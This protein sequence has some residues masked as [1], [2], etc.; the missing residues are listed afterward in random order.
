MEAILI[1][2]RPRS[3]KSTLAIILKRYIGDKA[4]ILDGDDLRNSLDYTD[5][6]EEGR[7]RWI[8]RVAS[9]AL[10]FVRQGFCPII[11]L[12]SPYAGVRKEI[13]EIFK[14]NDIDFTLF[15]VDGA[16]DRMWSGSVYEEPQ[17]DEQPITI[18]FPKGFDYAKVFDVFSGRVGFPRID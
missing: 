14:N 15:Y 12:V 5:F 4:I 9:L 8:K 2:G 13:G 17:E 18:K 3:G 7:K 6:S 11:A 1:T 10:T 16:A